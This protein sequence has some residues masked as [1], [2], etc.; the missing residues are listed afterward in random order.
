MANPVPDEIDTLK[1]INQ[2]DVRTVPNVWVSPVGSEAA[3]QV[4]LYRRAD[5]GRQQALGSMS[6]H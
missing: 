1:A 2:H 5:V 3:V 4:A 6:L